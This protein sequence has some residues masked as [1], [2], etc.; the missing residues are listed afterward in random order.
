MNRLLTASAVLTLAFTN[1]TAY[2]GTAE[3]STDI[4]E[5]LQQ[6]INNQQEEMKQNSLSSEPHSITAE[7]NVFSALS[8]GN[9][10]D[11]AAGPGVLQYQYDPQP[12]GVLSGY[13]SGFITNINYHWS[14]T[15]NGWSDIEVYLCLINAGVCAN[16]SSTPTGSISTSYGTYSGND[17]IQFYFVVDRAPKLRIYNGPSFNYVSA[18][19]E[20]Q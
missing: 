1:M 4:P 13:G 6:S 11:S 8:T 3:F 16:V 9:W 17:S 2:A 18:S 19:V 10:W 5:A 20:Y 14:G 15:L 12:S 7:P